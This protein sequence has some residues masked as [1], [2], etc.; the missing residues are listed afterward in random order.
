MFML[1]L[2]LDEGSKFEGHLS[3]KFI[4]MEPRY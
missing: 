1:I 2:K 4:D 3:V